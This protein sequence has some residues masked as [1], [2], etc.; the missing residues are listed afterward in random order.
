[1]SKEMP[2]LISSRSASIIYGTGI[3]LIGISY[4]LFTEQIA[5]L[6]PHFLPKR[7]FVVY[8]F[9][10]AFMLGGGAIIL[11]KENARMATYLLII[12]LFCASVVI[13]LRSAFNL[14]DDLKPIYLQSF[15]KDIG[16]ISGAMII[17]NFERIS[18]RRHGRH[19]SSKAMDSGNP[20]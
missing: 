9:G 12:L 18:K 14:P 10:L 19:R 3:I 17:A 6:L 13:D 15:L 1:M 2:S 20:I 7:I 4:F 11:N 16:L 5:F 8:F